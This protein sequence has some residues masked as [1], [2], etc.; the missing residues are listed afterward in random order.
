ML[1]G[2]ASPHGCPTQRSL[3]SGCFLQLPQRGRAGTNR[4]RRHRDSLLS[5]SA[6]S[7]PSHHRPREH[8]CA[9]A[10]GTEMIFRHPWEV[11]FRFLKAWP[12]TRLAKFA[13]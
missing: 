10:P 3:L 13:L 1:R 12:T 5:N 6:R 9:A 11:D 4:N 7:Y 8:S 2:W